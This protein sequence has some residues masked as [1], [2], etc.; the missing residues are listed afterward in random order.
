MSEDKKISAKELFKDYVPEVLEYDSRVD[1]SYPREIKKA[2][3]KKA[4]TPIITTKQA[5]APIYSEYF[6]KNYV[7]EVLEYDEEIDGSDEHKIRENHLS[8][9]ENLLEQIRNAKA[10]RKSNKTTYRQPIR[11]ENDKS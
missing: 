9:K 4:E 2:K 3:T 7:P 11:T 8:I 5:T 10:S 6:L 1:A